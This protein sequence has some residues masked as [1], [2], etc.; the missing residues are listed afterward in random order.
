MRKLER[1]LIRNP[2]F[3]QS[4]RVPLF[5]KGL[6]FYPILQNNSEIEESYPRNYTLFNSREYGW[7]QNGAKVFIY[8]NI[9]LGQEGF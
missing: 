2:D 9:Q 5:T 8:S 1:S 7:L 3:S 4:L 6:R